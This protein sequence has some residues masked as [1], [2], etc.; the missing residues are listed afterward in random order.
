MSDIFILNHRQP[1]KSLA[2]LYLVIAFFFIQTWPLHIHNTAK[3]ET[4]GHHTHVKEL[5]DNG[6]HVAFDLSGN[7]TTIDVTG[8]GVM[9][10]L[11]SVSIQPAMVLLIFGFLA[12]YI[13]HMPRQR[14]TRITFNSSCSVLR[15]PLRAPPC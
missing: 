13:F 4:S 9:K 5:Q 6:L 12:L 8:K 2:M 11:G 14:T 7:E 10:A 1:V 15:P 3:Q